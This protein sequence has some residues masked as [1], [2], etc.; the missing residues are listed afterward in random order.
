MR[1]IPA[2]EQGIAVLSIERPVC[3]TDLGIVVQK[4][5]HALEPLP[6]RAGGGVLKVDVGV[7][8]AEFADP[9]RRRAFQR[10]VRPE[11]GPRSYQALIGGRIVEP[12]LP[13]QVGPIVMGRINE[14]VSY[15][16]DDR[17]RARA[18]E[19]AAPPIGVAVVLLD[20]FDAYEQVGIDG[21]HRIARGLRRHLPVSRGIAVAPAC[22][23]VGFISQVHPDHRWVSLVAIRDRDPVGY[24]RVL[25]I[26]VGV[27]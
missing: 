27:P 7:R 21:E 19:I 2:V 1:S 16:E 18:F 23:I 6:L 17:R 24:P 22:A 26:G 3:P 13:R 11:L 14:P 20:S 12:W 10:K 5:N 8:A 4:A 15:G 25:R 9:Y